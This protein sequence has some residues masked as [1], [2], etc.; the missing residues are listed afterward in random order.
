[1]DRYNFT[2]LSS[3]LTQANRPI[4]LRLRGHDTALD[5]ILLVKH[6]TGKESLC[7]AIDYQLLCR[8]KQAALP[9]KTFIALSAELQFL[10]K[11]NCD[12]YAASCP[13]SESCEIFN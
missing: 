12:P 4:R 5:D 10:T 9:L 3:R 11:A 13:R 1:M 2:P 6:V 7:G 8:S